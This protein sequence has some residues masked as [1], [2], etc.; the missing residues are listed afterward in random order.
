M[1][2]LTGVVAVTG[3]TVHTIESVR[4]IQRQ[5]EYENEPCHLHA[6]TYCLEWGPS[7][8]WPLVSTTQPSP[9]PHNII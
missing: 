3:F 7:M 8:R 6:V 5:G 2:R 1:L 9:A 4:G